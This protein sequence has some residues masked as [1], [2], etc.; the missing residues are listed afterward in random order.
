MNFNLLFN[1]IKKGFIYLTSQIQHKFLF[2]KYLFSLVLCF[3]V[4]SIQAQN[5]STNYKVW[6][7]FFKEFKSAIVKDNEN[8]ILLLSNKTLA[9]M[10]AKEWLKSA[11]SGSEFSTL[12]GVINDLKVESPA[13]NKKIIDLADTNNCFLDFRLT[14]TGWKLFNV[15]YYQD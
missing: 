4:F 8:K 12:Q 9:D 13:A 7:E 5:Q 2:M 10:P 1:L 11:K 3:S 15:V 6:S 14:P